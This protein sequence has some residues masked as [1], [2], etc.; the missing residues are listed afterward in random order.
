[1]I[2]LKF[3]TDIINWTASYLNS[4][5]MKVKINEVT[6]ENYKMNTGVPAGSILG[7]ILFLIYINDLPSIF[8][9]YYKVLLFADDCKLVMKIKDESDT[10]RFQSEI[11]KLMEWCEK[12]NWN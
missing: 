7:P 10:V 9:R 5:L 11:N 8:D 2:S 3:D 12:K 1:M 4:R 6:S